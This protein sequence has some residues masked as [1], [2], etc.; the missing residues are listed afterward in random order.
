MSDESNLSAKV[1]GK[2][3]VIRIKMNQKPEPSS[4]GKTL[5]VAS[6]RGNKELQVKVQGQPVICGLNCYIYPPE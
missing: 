6:T 5:V 4:T 3:L 2:F 1:D